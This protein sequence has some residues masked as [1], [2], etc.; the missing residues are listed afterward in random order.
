MPILRWIE[1]GIKWMY[2]GTIAGHEIWTEER[3]SIP[4]NVDESL[5]EGIVK[6]RKEIEII[7]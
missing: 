4:V 1:D 2:E 6:G 7:P 3:H 5:V